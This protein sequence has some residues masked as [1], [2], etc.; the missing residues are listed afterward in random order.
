M[1]TIIKLILVILSIVLAIGVWTGIILL[2]KNSSVEPIRALTI[3]VS[4]LT[5]T[6]WLLFVGIVLI[7]LKLMFRLAKSLSLV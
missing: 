1:Q 4:H 3:W 2:F 5:F 6:G 7:V